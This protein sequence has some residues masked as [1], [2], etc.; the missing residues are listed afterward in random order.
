M[1]L[2]DC[3][4][5]GFVTP[6]DIVALGLE[7]FSV[8]ARA[9]PGALFPLERERRLA[10]AA[11]SSLFLEGGSSFLFICCAGATAVT[12]VGDALRIGYGTR[13]RTT[14]RRGE[15]GGFL[16]ELAL[17]FTLACSRFFLASSLA[18]SF[19]SDFS[20]LCSSVCF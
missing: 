16:V 2:D 18:C 6:L 12:G 5:F 13:E 11:F 14:S 8:C 20:A 10:C 19:S 3:A 9:A 7:C 4:R 1:L 17:A 15:G